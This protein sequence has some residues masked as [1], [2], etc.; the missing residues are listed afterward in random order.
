MLANDSI[1]C[2]NPGNCL[3]HPVKHNTP[4]ALELHSD[5]VQAVEVSIDTIQAFVEQPKKVK[6]LTAFDTISVNNVSLFYEPT[7]TPV[8][9]HNVSKQPEMVEP[10][11]YDILINAAL[12]TFM[13]GLTAKYMLSCGGAWVNL[14][15]E[16]KKEIAA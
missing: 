5:T 13:L 8:L 15:N 10:M 16:L 1:K 12:F 11:Q 14:F 7:Y 9:I 6:V 4:Q 2:K 3:N